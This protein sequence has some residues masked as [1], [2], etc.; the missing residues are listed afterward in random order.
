MSVRAKIIEQTIQEIE[1]ARSGKGG[2]FSF[3][4]YIMLCEAQ[5]VGFLNSR[6]RKRI[7]APRIEEEVRVSIEKG[8]FATVWD[9]LLEGYERRVLLFQREPFDYMSGFLAELDELEAQSRY[10]D[11][12]RQ[13]RL[14]SY[15]EELKMVL[16]SNM[17]YIRTGK[18]VYPLARFLPNHWWWRYDPNVDK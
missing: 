18:P 10:V 17:A 4:E 8:F 14:R 16:K 13:Q 2:Y 7:D 15:D 9:E 11:E 12:D 6:W 5:E 1:R 3:C